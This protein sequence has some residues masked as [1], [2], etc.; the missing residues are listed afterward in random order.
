MSH[1]IPTRDYDQDLLDHWS[2]DE[3]DRLWE[4]YKLE[5]ERRGLKGSPKDFLQWLEERL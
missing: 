5:N 2:P 3:L 1:P 4:L